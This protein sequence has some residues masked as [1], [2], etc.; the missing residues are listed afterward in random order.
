MKILF[1]KYFLKY[2]RRNK[3]LKTKFIFILFV[4]Y[5]LFPQISIIA[6][7]TESKQQET[8]EQIEQ[9]DLLLKKYEIKEEGV[10]IFGK[11]VFSYYLKLGPLSSKD[12][13]QL[14]EKKIQDILTQG[15]WDPSK[16]KI[17]K[18]EI[19]IDIFYDKEI[20][21]TLTQADLEYW[22][23]LNQ[24][25]YKLE[26]YATIIIT[27]LN[28]ELKTSYWEFL[29]KKILL[30]L[31]YAIII[32]IILYFL[33][34]YTKKLFIKLDQKLE[35]LKG[36]WIKP[37]KI[38]N[39]ELL[40]E[41]RVI[42]S[43]KYLLIGI[44]YVIYLIYF[45]I[46]LSILFI[47][48]PQTK[49][50]AIKLLQYAWNPVKTVFLGIIS[51]LPNVFFILVISATTYYALKFIN[52]IFKEIEKGTLKIPG[53]YPDYVKPTYQLVRIIVIAFAFA[54]VFPYLPGHDS[55]A[56]Q[57]ISVFVGVLFSLGSTGAISNMVSGLVLTY[58][59]AFHAG[60]YIK[61]GDTF[62]KVI[63]KGVLVTRILTPK[64]VQITIPNSQILSSHIINFS[65]QENL[66]L[67]TT[68]TIG[69]DVPWKKVHELLIQSA[70]KVE[71]IKKEPSP[72]VLQTSL[73]DFYVSYEL[74][75]FTDQFD[76]MPKLYSEIH[77][78]I[79][80]LFNENGVEILSPHYR[81]LRDGNMI[82][83]PENYL[84]KNYIPPS[85]RVNLQKN[86]K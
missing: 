21:I 26:E 27:Q 39:V 65:K 6:Q 1:V 64:N 81:A 85:F 24:T 57:G 13:A 38:Q 67:H 75:A 16:I 45:Y 43:L 17:E 59:R 44:R 36:K 74:N 49:N 5:C 61:I 3:Q 55:P 40:N 51:Y 54:L 72:F 42:L 66:I 50:I 33:I 48:F 58:M 77:Q 71:G 76:K 15:K 23:Q 9:E 63:E 34:K 22:N 12:R 14:T 19:G 37:I 70:L 83:I 56:F 8:I 32:T 10:T 25:N 47:F 7:E 4:V 46:Y 69:Y 18:S 80:D 86:E 20:L 2:N 52:F 30:G 82:T 73:D 68:V 31:L 84:D 28:N 11:K 41:D 35:Q 79:Q 78:N 60:D 53:F 29:I 62:G